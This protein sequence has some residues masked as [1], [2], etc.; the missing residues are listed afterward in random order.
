MKNTILTTSLS[1]MLCHALIA[2]PA[3]DIAKKHAAASAT[4]LEAYLK[5]NP[6]AADKNRAVQHLLM[7]YNLTGETQKSIGVFQQ[8]FND[9]GSGAK[10]DAGVLYGTTRS[11]FNLLIKTGNKEAAQKL[12]DDATKKS[13]GN[14]KAAQLAQAF[15]QMEGK[16]NKPSKGDTMEMKFTSLQGKE[17]DLADMK[18]KVVLIDFWATWCGPCIA[19]LPHVLTTYEKYHEQGF[20]IIGISLDKEEDKA[21]LEKFIANKNMPWPQHFDGKGWGNELAKKYGIGSIPA[22]FLIGADGKIVATD[23]RGEALEKT[24]GKH[25][26]K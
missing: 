7:A 12:I 23:L 5:D 19:E 15:S 18:G 24:V 8:K 17:I 21:K 9:L 22:T 25:L 20:E 26:A 16:L 13:A 6:D 2:G 14:P 10:V 4:E 11:L 3:D 1:L